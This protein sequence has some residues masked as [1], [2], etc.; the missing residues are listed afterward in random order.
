MKQPLAFWD[1]HAALVFALRTFAAAMLALSIALWLD[2]PRPYWAMASVSA[3]L[4][5]P[6]PAVSV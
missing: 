2:M 4:S 6:N 3:S 5:G 1:R